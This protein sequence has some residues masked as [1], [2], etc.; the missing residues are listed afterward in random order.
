M[1]F[2][3]D[4]PDSVLIIRRGV[5]TTLPSENMFGKNPQDNKGKRGNPDLMRSGMVTLIGVLHLTP[6]VPNLTSANNV[7]SPLPPPKNSKNMSKST[8]P[9]QNLSAHQ[10]S[11]HPHPG[12]IHHQKYQP[13]YSSHRR[14]RCR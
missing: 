7:A 1:T 5:A 6:Q 9:V 3:I 4:N 12:W 14:I 8:R 13:S 2:S 11:L 10:K